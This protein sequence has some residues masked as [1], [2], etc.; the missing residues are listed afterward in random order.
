MT[1]LPS[2]KSPR[3]PHSESAASAYLASAAMVRLVPGS[4]ALVP[5]VRRQPKAVTSHCHPTAVCS[6]QDH[7]FGA[8]ARLACT[9]P[10]AAVAVQRARR[11]G[12]AGLRSEPTSHQHCRPLVEAGRPW[13]VVAQLL[14][15]PEA[16]AREPLGRGRPPGR[17]ARR[18]K[19]SSKRAGRLTPSRAEVAV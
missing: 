7:R 6:G 3:P 15:P 10:V 2:T 16:T 17:L 11:A 1:A 18:L 13:Y 19:E 14:P 5:E 12:C 9:H 8:S 4:R